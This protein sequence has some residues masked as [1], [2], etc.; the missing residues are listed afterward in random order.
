MSVGR[1]SPWITAL[2][3]VGEAATMPSGM[4]SRTC[5]GIGAL[6]REAIVIVDELR[7]R[8]MVV[9]NKDAFV[10]LERRSEWAQKIRTDTHS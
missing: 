5:L 7:V 3:R 9:W 8:A 10:D 2:A 4:S 6:G 1:D